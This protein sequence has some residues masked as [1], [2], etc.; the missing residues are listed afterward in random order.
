MPTDVMHICMRTTLNIDDQLLLK[1]RRKALE[2]KTT[3]TRVVEESLRN[4]LMPAKRR[5]LK[6]FSQRWVVVGGK[7]PPPVDVADRDRLYDY[8]DGLRR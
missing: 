2:Q 5:P 3:L 8:L 6:P 4:Y 7:H 1:A